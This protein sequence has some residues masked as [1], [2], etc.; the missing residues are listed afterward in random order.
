MIVRTTAGNGNDPPCAE[1]KSRAVSSSSLTTST[2]PESVTR[3]FGGLVEMV[4][5]NSPSTGLP[6]RSHRP[7]LAVETSGDLVVH[8]EGPTDH[9]GDAPDRGDALAGRERPEGVGVGGGRLGARGRL[10]VELGDVDTLG[11][12]LRV[13]VL[14]DPDRAVRVRQALL[15]GADVERAVGLLV[16]RVDRDR[17][18]GDRFVAGVLHLEDQVAGLGESLASGEL[19]R[20]DLD[21]ELARRL[22]L[23]LAFLVAPAG[24]DSRG[25]EQACRCGDQPA[26]APNPG[27]A[28]VLYLSPPR[29]GQ[30]TI[31][32]RCRL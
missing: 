10:G 19:G 16:A 18:V 23:V 30:H 31:A 15:V 28:G 29:R 20:V 17:Q 4:A 21:R 8:G 27:A 12:H 25:G 2:S 26:A 3:V 32:L 7:G 22:V 1:A 24:C 5:T 13:G 11:E 6:S 14:E 9:G